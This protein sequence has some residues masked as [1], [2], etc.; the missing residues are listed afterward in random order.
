MMTLKDIVVGP[1]GVTREVVLSPS[2]E[3]T[4]RAGW[5]ANAVPKPSQVDAERDQRIKFFSFDGKLYRLDAQAKADITAFGA[6][7]KLAVLAG[8][9]AGDLFWGADPDVPKGF[10][11]VDNTFTPMDAPTGSLF[12]DTA[13]L[14]YERHIFAGR[15]IKDLPEI[16]ADFAADRR[17]P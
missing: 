11:A 6:R 5:V 14:W 17:W 16:P 1:D 12:A 9:G 8:K 10:I 15:A 3:A 2:E 7:A 4:R 13:D